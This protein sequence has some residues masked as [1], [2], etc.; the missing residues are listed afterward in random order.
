MPKRFTDSGLWE[1]DWFLSLAPVEMLLWMYMKDKCDYTGLW[2]VN[3]T[4]FAQITKARN[5]NLEGFLKKVNKGKERLIQISEDKWF[6]A[7]FIKFQYGGVMNENNRFHK[8]ILKKL[9]DYGITIND[10]EVTFKRE[11]VDTLSEGVDRDKVKVKVIKEGGMGEEKPHPLC[12]YVKRLK[13]VSSLRDQLTPEESDRLLAEFPKDT[14]AEVLTRMENW[15]DLTRKNVSVNLTIRD[16]IKRDRKKAGGSQPTS[17]A[18]KLH[19]SLQ[20]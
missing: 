2:K 4:Q 15:K 3:K 9:S 13:N 18:Y 16:W 5:I 20:K 11:G 7:G 10:G 19:P 12:E 1:E 8:S 17:P 14:I 6:L